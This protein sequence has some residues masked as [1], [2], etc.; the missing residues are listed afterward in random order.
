MD[1]SINMPLIG[2]VV[3]LGPGDFVLDGD[4][5]PSPKGGGAP[6]Q[7]SAQFYCGRTAECI[8]RPLGIEVGLGQEDFVLDGDPAPSPK[9]DRAPN[10][11]PSSI[12][13]KRM[14]GSRCHSVRR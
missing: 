4:P 10:F 8:K 13:V 3:G 6:P 11:R 12:V 14:H 5:G 7:F 9:R 2:M 1:A